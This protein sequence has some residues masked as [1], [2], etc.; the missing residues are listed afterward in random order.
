MN[1]IKAQYILS[2]SLLTIMGVGCSK[3]D[4]I[5]TNPNQPTEVSSAMLA[6]NMILSITRGDIS[7]TKAFV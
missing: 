3:F 2:L 6:T 7:S 1:K 4:K 5:N